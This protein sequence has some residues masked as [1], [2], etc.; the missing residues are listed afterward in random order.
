MK[1]PVMLPVHFAKKVILAC[2]G[3]A[4]FSVPTAVGSVPAPIMLAQVSQAGSP[5]SID[6]EPSETPEWQVAAGGTMSFEVA[7]VKPIPQELRHSPNF[8][9]DNRNAFV[10]GGRF[11]ATFPLWVYI[12]FAYKL[13]L[14]E[15]RT[16]LT[17]LPAWVNSYSDLFAIEARAEGSPTKD[18]MRLMMQSLLAERFKLAVHFET[19]EVPVLALTLVKP[20]QT[21]PKLRPHSEGPPCPDYTP[22][23]LGPPISRS[24]GGVFPPDCDT[25]MLQLNGMIERLGSRN[26]TMPSLADAI[27]GSH[28][29]DQLVIDGTGLNGTFDFTL[30]Y[31]GENPATSLNGPPPDPQGSSFLSALREQ[32]GLKLVPS[33]AP[34]RML[35][36]DHFERPSEN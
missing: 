36:I 11:S 32:L 21:G 24:P 30:E 16:T 25:V 26:T 33:K 1:N 18:Q 35:V 3:M 7:S 22:P 14:N 31:T 19:R 8:P 20:G 23:A 34:V 13:W 9:L 10:Q 28:D 4:A 6:S 17:H 15:G 27:S 29:V 2:A 12:K 5:P